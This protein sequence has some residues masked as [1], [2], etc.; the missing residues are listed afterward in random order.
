MRRRRAS[1]GLGRLP[2]DECAFDGPLDRFI[3]FTPSYLSCQTFSLMSSW[4]GPGIN[5]NVGNFPGDPYPEIE[6][7]AP[8]AN[9]VRFKTYLGGGVW[10]TRSR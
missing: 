1:A 8:H 10:Y 4:P 6:K 3:Y 2:C 7:I 5:L 9:I